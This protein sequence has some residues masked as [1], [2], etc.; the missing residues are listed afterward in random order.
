MDERERRRAVED[1][2]AAIRELESAET[3]AVPAD[4]PPRGYYVL[5]HVVFGMML[6]GLGALVSLGAN[7]IGAPLLG[8][9]PLQLIRVF[10]T[11]PMGVAALTAEGGLVLTVGCLLYH[12]TGMVYGIFVHMVTSLFFAESPAGTRFAVVTAI[13]LGIWIVNFYVVLSWLQP[14]LLG[15]DW[16]VT[17]IPWWVGA[18]THLSF[19]WTIFLGE[20]FAGRFQAY[21]R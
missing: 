12:G 16:I 9:H 5:W 15:G 7:A 13:G 10:L 14:L 20:I 8:V 19:V 17:M 3:S 18:L 11:F 4:W 21:A 6:G 1:H 2:L